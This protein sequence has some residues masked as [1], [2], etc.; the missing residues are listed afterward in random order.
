MVTVRVNL[1]FVTL[2]CV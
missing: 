1:N 2:C